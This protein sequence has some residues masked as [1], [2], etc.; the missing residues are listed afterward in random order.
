LQWLFD[1]A[2]LGQMI[3]SYDVLVVVRRGHLAG[4]S[5]FDLLAADVQWNLNSLVPHLFISR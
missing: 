5:C 4:I 2:F 1:V 3:G